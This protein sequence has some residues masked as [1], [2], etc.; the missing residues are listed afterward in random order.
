MGWGDAQVWMKMAEE[1]YEGNLQE[2][3]EGKALAFPWIN[4][5]NVA[6]VCAGYAFELLYKVLVQLGGE[7]PDPKHQIKSSHEKLCE[8]DRNEI[9]EPLINS[10]FWRNYSL[11]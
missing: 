7:T 3:L 8:S 10:A 9:K 1:L 4:E 6:C 11:C 5:M 2:G